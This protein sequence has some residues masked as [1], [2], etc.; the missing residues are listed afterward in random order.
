[1]S[2]HQNA[3]QNKKYKDSWFGIIFK[4]VSKYKDVGMTVINQN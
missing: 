2:P 4:N 3:R 1:M